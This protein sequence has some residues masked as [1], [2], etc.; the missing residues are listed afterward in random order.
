MNALLVYPEFPDTFWSF[1]Y[2]LPFIRRKASSPPLGLL[3]V[4]ALL[5]GQWELR[6]VDMNAG[7]LRDDDL[8]WADVALVSAM[9]VQKKSVRPEDLREAD[10]AA[11]HQGRTPVPLIPLVRS[12]RE[13]RRAKATS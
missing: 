8:Q 3:T 4:A 7:N 2:A 11:E 12:R 10:A 1:S 6:L 13:V 9:A 5:P